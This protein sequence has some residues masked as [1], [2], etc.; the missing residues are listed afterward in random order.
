MSLKFFA[1]SPT[2]PNTLDI[3]EWLESKLN[4]AVKL[5]N[6]NFREVIK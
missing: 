2:I 3:A 4:P 6:T 1:A 5:K